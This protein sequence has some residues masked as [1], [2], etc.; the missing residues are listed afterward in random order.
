M[1]SLGQ[2]DLATLKARLNELSVAKAAPVFWADEQNNPHPS[3]DHKAIVNVKDGHVF[4]IA[5]KGY[6]IIQHKD[7]FEAV[8]DALAA[9]GPDAKIRA[10]V[11]EQGGR[12][13]MTVVYEGEVAQDGAAGIALGLKV[14]NSYNLTSALKYSGSSK[15]NVEGKFEFF[16][17]RL[18]C[19]NGMTV[20]VPIDFNTLEVVPRAEAKKG[21]IVDVVY[22]H[23]GGVHRDV[24][25]SYIRH[26]GKK[27]LVD[28]ERA[29]QMILALPL[30]AKSLERQIKNVKMIAYDREGARIRLKELNFGPLLQERI[31]KRFDQGEESTAWGL[32]NAITAYATHE[33]KVSPSNMEN[34]LKV[35][36]QILVQAR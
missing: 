36:E 30:V 34:T 23:N 7:A 6:T 24:A 4:A 12:A 22:A 27:A 2:T 1:R 21:D 18:A 31:L 32:Y 3:E 13:W 16:G 20:R 19:M 35:A 5:S 28:V 8:V 14:S 11:M 26:F 29:R 10:S 15:E 33:E 25:N 17:L 9:M